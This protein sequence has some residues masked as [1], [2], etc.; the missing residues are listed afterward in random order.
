KSKDFEVDLSGAVR[1]KDETRK[2]ILTEYQRNKQEEI[3]HPLLKQ[4]VKYGLLPHF[5][6]K[7]LAKAI[8]DE[9]KTYAPY[10]IK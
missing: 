7:L 6:A 9:M 1:M 2:L 5:Q 8:R 4:K 3:I 10:L